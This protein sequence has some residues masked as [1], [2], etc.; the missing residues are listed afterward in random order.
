MD[1]SWVFLIV[2]LD[3]DG[4]QDFFIING[5]GKDIIDFDFVKFRKNVVVFFFS[6]DEVE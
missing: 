3:N 5:Y 2:D 4:F 1:W 6:L